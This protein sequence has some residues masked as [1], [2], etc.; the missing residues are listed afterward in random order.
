MV[1]LAVAV[2]L[3]IPEKK[4]QGK[5]RRQDDLVDLE[6]PISGQN[7]SQTMAPLIADD[8]PVIL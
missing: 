2:A 4:K 3:F 7:S 8:N 1:I 5:I 6:N